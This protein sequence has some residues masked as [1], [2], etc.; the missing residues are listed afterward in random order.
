MIELANRPFYSISEMDSIL[1]ANWNTLISRKDEVYVLGDFSMNNKEFIE[2]KLKLLNGVKY[3]IKGNHDR[4]GAYPYKEIRGFTWIK[5]YHEM[6]Y[7]GVRLVLFHYPIFEWSRYFKGSVHLYG[8][9]HG[10]LNYGIPGRG[11]GNKAFS[12][13][14]GVDVNNYFPI[15]AKNILNK[16]EDW[17]INTAYG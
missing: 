5:D 15:S 12:Y 6:S 14:V 17:R 11:D 16:F 8:H 9:V 4:C 10:T 13:N 1:I 2:D 3:L 7:E